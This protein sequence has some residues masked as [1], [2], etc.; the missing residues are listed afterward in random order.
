MVFTLRISPLDDW[1]TQS[2]RR[3]GFFTGPPIKAASGFHKIS[4]DPFAA[5]DPVRET[6]LTFLELT[7]C[8]TNLCL[9]TSPSADT[10]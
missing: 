7:S 8:Q 3:P 1:S 5:A 2:C 4:V 6:F 9:P 10:C